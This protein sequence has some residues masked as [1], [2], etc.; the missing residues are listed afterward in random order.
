MRYS[1]AM[2]VKALSEESPPGSPY[3]LSKK[4]RVV[5]SA[6]IVYTLVAVFL[7]SADPLVEQNAVQRFFYPY[8]VW[9]RLLQSWKLFTPTPRKHMLK[10]RADL[11]F[12]DGTSKSWMR[13]YPPNWAFFPRHLS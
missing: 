10:Y 5:I 9:T 6:W 3:P 4:K 2:V 1:L 7:G 12:K 8:L 13:P 11:V